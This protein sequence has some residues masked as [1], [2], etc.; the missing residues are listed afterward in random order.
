M[1]AADYTRF[2]PLALGKWKSGKVE[3]WKSSAT[4]FST[5]QLF[6]YSTRAKRVGRAFGLKERSRTA[7]VGLVLHFNA[8]FRGIGERG[9]FLRCKAVIVARC[10]SSRTFRNTL[11]TS[12]AADSGESSPIVTER[13]IGSHLSRRGRRF[14]ESDA[15]FGGAGSGGWQ[16][17]SPS[18]LFSSFRSKNGWN[19]D[20]IF[21]PTFATISNFS[22]VSRI[23]SS[24][25]LSAAGTKRRRGAWGRAA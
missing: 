23:S 2:S 7:S 8:E 25:A 24:S 16:V 18:V 17:P 3:E 21:L 5:I 15:F 20:I 12:S 11:S 22:G 10:L 1:N 9:E 4:H 14:A 6:Y 13:A 19:E